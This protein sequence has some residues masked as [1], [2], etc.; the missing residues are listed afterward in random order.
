MHPPRS[1][2]APARHRRSRLPSSTTAR[3]PLRTTERAMP[4][5]LITRRLFWAAEAL[6]LAGTIVAGVWL[7]RP[8]E[9]HPLA[10]V[11]LLL[12]IAF[13][14]ELFT[15]ETSGGILSASL[16]VTA[17]AMGLLGPAQRHC[18]R[19]RQSACIRRSGAGRRPMAEQPRRLRDPRL[20]GGT[21]GPRGGRRCGR[22]TQ[23]APRRQPHLRPRCARRG[24]G[25]SRPQ[26]RP[27]RVRP[28]HQQ[29]SAAREPASA[30]CSCRCFPASSQSAW[31]RRSSCSPTEAPACRS[32]WR[33]S[34]SC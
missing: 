18:A 30:N 23:P 17:L 24:S 15:V 31:S 12:V 28:A 11:A 33:P 1:N 26:L 19:S 5:S 32:C 10:L 2:R 16:G 3:R 8:G 6:L 25:V 27:V 21:G 34:R 7:E 9:W 29:R 14:G 22:R 4:A 20:R 13:G